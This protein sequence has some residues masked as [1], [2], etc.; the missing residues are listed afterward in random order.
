MSRHED[1]ISFT[2]KYDRVK[3]DETYIDQR[4][5][6][7]CCCSVVKPKLRDTINCEGVKP[8]CTLI[9]V[10]QLDHIMSSIL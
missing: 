6:P 2:I 7:I 9:F 8:F 10:C 4:D 5:K 3:I 1:K